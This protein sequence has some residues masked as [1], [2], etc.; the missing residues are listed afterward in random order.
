MCS[1]RAPVVEVV[2]DMAANDLK[3]SPRLVRA[4][5]AEHDAIERQR[6]VLD[7]RRSKLLSELADIESSLSTLGEREMLLARLLAADAPGEAQATAAASEQASRDEANAAASHTEVGEL[8]RGPAIREAA[9]A[10]LTRSNAADAIHYRAWYEMLES[11]GYRVAGK[12]PLAVFLTQITRSPVVRRSTQAG[13]YSLDRE[14]PLR[15][16]RELARLE[17]SLREVASDAS[18][19][20]TV[21]RARR[22]EVLGRIRQ[23]ERALVEAERVLGGVSPDRAAVG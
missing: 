15:L 10:V 2:E 6:R 1:V 11:A 5:G 20:L 21:V 7:E 17:T 12:D 14:S 18:G 8:L 4:A 13:V 22:D 16:R 9:V 19:D 23:T 3:P